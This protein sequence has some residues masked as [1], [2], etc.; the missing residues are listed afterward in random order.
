MSEGAA[1]LVT[2]GALKNVRVLDLSRVLAGPWAAQTLGDLG[3]EVIKVERPGVGDDTRHW[4]PPFLTDP[5]GQPTGESAYYLCANRNKK[6]VTIDFT[7]AA[8]QALVR[9]LA[10]QCDVVV[11][12]FKSGGLTQYGLDAPGVLLD[13]RFRPDRPLCAPGRL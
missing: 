1:S 10:R 12:N 5:Q 4:G 2:P 13:H 6:S 11:E 8:G 3:A 7:Q 9:E